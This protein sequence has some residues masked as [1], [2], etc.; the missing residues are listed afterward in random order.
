MIITKDDPGFDHSGGYHH[1]YAN[2]K[3]ME[4]YR[5]GRFPD[6][7][8]IV[9]DFIEMVEKKGAIEE[10]RRKFIDVMIKN[11][12]RYGNTGGWGFE[13]FDADSREKRMVGQEKAVTTC[14][15]CHTRKADADFVFSTYRK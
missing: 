11:D 4:G 13:E 8:I 7:A 10:G 2:D 3:A 14:Y 12:A 1:I 15:N 5:T 6:G 9:A